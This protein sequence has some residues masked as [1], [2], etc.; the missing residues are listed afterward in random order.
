ML[1]AIISP[2]KE[3]LS[4]PN[5]YL[6]VKTLKLWLL[7]IPKANP[8]KASGNFI[9]QLETINS[10]RYPV[11]ERILLMDTLRPTARQ[12]IVS[13]KRVTKQASLPLSAKAF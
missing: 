5:P 2:R 12:L 6:R 13:L 4:R 10:N 11:Y 3:E 1:N 9:Q 7:N 8:L